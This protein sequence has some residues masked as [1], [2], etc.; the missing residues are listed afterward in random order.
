MAEIIL[1]L[2]FAIPAVLGLAEI[3]HSVKMWLLKP[4]NIGKRI[5]VL[6]PNTEDFEKQILSAYE[7]L[8]WQG[9]KI[10]DKVVVVDYLVDQKEECK[11]LTEELGIEFCALSELTENVV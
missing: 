10:A 4:K 7:Q 3:I 8:K 5:L 6:I 2:V 1:N 9:K 11:R